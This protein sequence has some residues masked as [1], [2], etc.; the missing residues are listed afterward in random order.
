M[1][2]RAWRRAS[3]RRQ[4]GGTHVGNE[5]SVILHETEVWIK[6]LILQGPAFA[7]RLPSAPRVL[8]PF[9]FP[10]PRASLVTLSPVSS[11]AVPYSQVSS[12]KARPGAW[13]LFFFSP[14]A[15]LSSTS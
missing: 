6:W 7:R 14:G 11:A 13:G 9:C 2:A 4:P 10:H 3:G 5:K 8:T 12:V 15:H 1:L